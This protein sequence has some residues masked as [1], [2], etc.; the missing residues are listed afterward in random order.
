MENEFDAASRG[1]AYRLDYY[2]KLKGWLPVS[3]YYDMKKRGIGLD[4]VLV[5]T[6]DADGFSGLPEMAE[7][8]PCTNIDNGRKRAGWYNVDNQKID[9]ELTK[10]A[11]FK[12]VT[13]PLMDVQDYI[14]GACEEVKQKSPDWK[15]SKDEFN[16]A[17]FGQAEKEKDEYVENLYKYL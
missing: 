3:E 5:I 9:N 13:N 7:F 15:F 16:A 6:V 8:L 12:C 14:E 17:L 2:M 11:Y 10:V 1:I 4:W